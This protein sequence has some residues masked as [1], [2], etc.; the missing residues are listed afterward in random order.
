MTSP[1]DPHREAGTRE[2]LALHDL[3]GQPELG[4]HLPDLV[5]EQVAERLD[6]L[7]LHLLGEP[8]DVVMALDVGRGARA[9]LDHVRIE[10]ALD[11][12]PCVSVLARDL[13]EDADELLADRAAL[14]L[15]VGDARRASRGSGPRAFTWTS[16]TP[17]CRPN[18]SSTCCGS[19]S[20]FNPWSTKTQVSWSP[21]A[22][23]T[24][25]AATEE[26]TPP[27]SAHRTSASPTCSRI[28]ATASST[29]FT[30]VQSGS[31]PQPS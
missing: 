31:S 23:C 6:E 28:R 5:L 16:G 24:R 27:E 12:E 29:M 2:R 7:E 25:S 19:P 22:R 10:G 15:G 21:T 13:L 4:A 26:S 9:A 18:V 20:R 11:E 8:A 17:K 1:D 14:L 30:G 3:L